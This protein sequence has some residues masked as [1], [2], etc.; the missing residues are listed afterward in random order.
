MTL[1]IAVY[2]TNREAATADERLFLAA[3]RFSAGRV[4]EEG[5]GVAAEDAGHPA[6]LALGWMLAAVRGQSWAGPVVATNAS[7]WLGLSYYRQSR[8]DLDGAREAARLAVEI[9][10]DFGFGWARLGELEFSFGRVSAAERAIQRALELSPGN[11][12][13]YALSGFLWLARDRV[14]EAEAAFGRSIEQ[15]P[16]LGNAWLGRG[17]GRI[18]QGQVSAGRADL[19]AAAILEPTR[20]L[21]RSYL[22]KAYAHEALFTR[23]PGLRRELQELAVAELELAKGRDAMDPTP[24]LYAALLMHDQYRTAAAIRD[25]EQS[26][27]RNDNRQV[28][29]SQLLL[30][31][32]QAVR[33]ANL[34]A[35]FADAGMTDVSLAESA[36]AVAFDYGNYSAHLNLA[37]SYEALRDPT[38]F[39]LRFESQWFNE[40]LL[41]S[42][43]APVGAGML[44]Q[45]LSQQEYSRLF[46]GKQFGLNN[47]TEYWSRGAVRQV[48]SHFGTV[49]RT[50]YA[51]DL[52]YQCEDGVRP[53]NDLARLEWYTRLK[54]QFGL[55][56]AAF[57]LIK[58]EDYDAGDHFQ[59]HDPGDARPDFRFEEQQAPMLLGGWHHQW[60]PGIHSLGLVG[61]LANEQ[62]FRDRAAD[63]RIA[64]VNPPG[65]AD[66]TNVVP[67]AVE[68]RSEFET[69]TV[70]LQQIIQRDRHTDLFGVRWQAGG[71]D[72]DAELDQPPPDLAPLFALPAVSASDADYWRLSVYGYHHWEIV[73]GLLLMG[74]L[75]Y[76]DLSYPANYRRPPLSEE[77]ADKQLWS[78]KAAV[79]WNVVPWLTFRAACAR[80]VGGASYDESVRLEPTQLAGFAQSFRS[81]VSESVVGSVEAPEYE[82]VGVAMDL[83]LG[84]RTRLTPQGGLRRQEVERQFGLFAMDFAN[85]PPAESVQSIEQLRYDESIGRITLNHILAPEWFGELQYQFT[86]SELERRL[87]TIPA[88]TNFERTTRA[89]A[90]LH[91]FRAAVAWQGVSGWF[92][93]GECWWFGQELEEPGVR[94]SDEAFPQFNIFAGYRFPRRRG[95]V[96]LGVLNLTDEDYR[97]SPLNY[98]AE[99]PRERTF[100]ARLRFN[101]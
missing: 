37:S 21:L 101:F 35:V 88:T 78:P 74:G 54:H 69:Y 73:E 68:Y 71:F 2:P 84:E 31:Q 93:R 22:G 1:C 64:V 14:A 36:R 30:D 9:S 86:R 49:G 10:Q 87:P 95:D 39:H 41:A 76:D 15:D 43:L 59:Y 65:F 79:I 58:Y 19:Q 26:V 98:Y 92:A 7:Q 29:R 56:D 60:G 55:Q 77:E 70:E 24:W 6:A 38:R 12:Q 5:W 61:R 53:N 83:K 16:M 44:S 97:L 62:R 46:A 89:R 32:D 63:Q 85:A 23:E 94:S 20:W 34:A 3:L 45:H 100:Y 28:Y 80:A 17:L 50:S 33:S 47:S 90:D 81:I 48:A 40:H 42:L 82:L 72:A 57:L 75:A 8:H 18:R 91:E 27:R 51:L 52:D 25:L 4:T 11:A 13:A 99:L 96:T 66:P 67:F